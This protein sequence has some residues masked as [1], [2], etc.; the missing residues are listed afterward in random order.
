MSIG[1][2]RRGGSEIH[3]DERGHGSERCGKACEGKLCAC[4]I[5]EAD[6]RQPSAGSGK[7][8]C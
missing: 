2:A 3:S 6:E 4:A 7:N 5:T 1:P 8:G